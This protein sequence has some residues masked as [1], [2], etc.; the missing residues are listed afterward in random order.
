[1]EGERRKVNRTL[2]EIGILKF[3]SVNN[4]NNKRIEH[5]VIVVYR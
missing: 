4:S 1:M 2:K 3:S 5:Q